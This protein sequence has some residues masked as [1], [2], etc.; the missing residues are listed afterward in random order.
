MA[1]VSLR[2]WPA[3]APSAAAQSALSAPAMCPTLRPS[4]IS[5]TGPYSLGSMY[6]QAAGLHMLLGRLVD[7]AL[8]QEAAGQGLILLMLL[9][10]P[11]RQNPLTGSVLACERCCTLCRWQARSVK[12]RLGST[13]DF[14]GLSCWR[15]SCRYLLLLV[16]IPR[17]FDACFSC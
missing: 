1:K 6:E 10:T 13:G 16:S 17:S 2:F 7:G 3:A 15:A 11:H 9:S 12:W 4:A 5:L 8:L 14:L